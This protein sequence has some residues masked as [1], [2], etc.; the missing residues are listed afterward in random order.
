[1]RIGYVVVTMARVG[2][3]DDEEMK[4]LRGEEWSRSVDQ[5]CRRK[6]RFYS[7]PPSLS[8]RR[9]FALTRYTDTDTKQ[10]MSAHAHSQAARIP[11]SPQIRINILDNNSNHELGVRC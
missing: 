7:P 11:P 10:I 9:T 2:S 6:R 8:S 5:P 4:G 1:M 3:S